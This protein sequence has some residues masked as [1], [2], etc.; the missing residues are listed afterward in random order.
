MHLQTFLELFHKTDLSRY[1]AKPI[2]FCKKGSPQL[3]LTQKF[4]WI[5]KTRKAGIYSFGMH[6]TKKELHSRHQSRY[7]RKLFGVNVGNCRFLEISGRTTFW[8][9]SV[10]VIG[11]LTEL[12]DVESFPTTLLKSDSSRS[13]P[14]YFEKLENSQEIF[15]VESVFSTAI[16]ST[17]DSDLYPLK[18]SFWKRCMTYSF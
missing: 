11:L 4:L 14:R 10:Q 8:N 18:T 6:F 3:T 5:S 17:L 12:Y 1:S 9:T 13:S 16:D 2:C 15:Q 7:L